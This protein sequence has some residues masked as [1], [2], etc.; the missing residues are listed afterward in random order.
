[1]PSIVQ[2]AV[3][4]Q[5]QFTKQPESTYQRNL[6][7]VSS[8]VGISASGY[9]AGQRLADALSGLGNAIMTYA[10]GQE[11]RKRVNAEKANDIVN[12]TTDK[13][14]KTLAAMD[15]INKSGQFQLRDNPYAVALIEQ[16][17]GKYFADKFNQQYDLLKAQEGVMKTP[18]E[19]AQRYE[20]EKTKF[21]HDNVDVAINE[22]NFHKGFYESN[23]KDVEDQVNAQVASQSKDL[24]AVRDGSI[25]AQTGEALVNNY[26]KT[27]EDL[28]TDLQKIPN[29]AMVT[30]FTDAEKIAWAQDTLQNV[31]RYYGS[32]DTIN[33]VGDMTL[34]A[35][36]ANGNPVKIKDVV[37]LSPFLQMAEDTN[38][39]KPSMWTMQQ[40]EAMIKT[41]SAA[42]LDALWS[43][44][45]PQ[46]QR[47]MKPFYSRQRLQKIAEA[48]EAK[49]RMVERNQRVLA[50]QASG[51]LLLNDYQ[52][53]IHNKTHIVSV[54]KGMTDEDVMAALL[55]EYERIQG[56]SDTNERN[57][58]FA[59]FIAYP[60]NKAL[61]AQLKDKYEW[62]LTSMTAEQMAEDGSLE[63]I[64]AAMNLYRN[65][66]VIFESN[67][68]KSLAD[69]MQTIKALIDLDGDEENAYKTFVNARVALNDPARREQVDAATK[70]FMDN[71]TFTLLNADTNEE[72]SDLTYNDRVI[73]SGAQALTRCLLATGLPMDAVASRVHS[74]IRNSYVVYNSD[75]NTAYYQIIPK[76]FF[77]EAQVDDNGN[78]QTPGIYS[79]TPYATATGFMDHEIATAP[80]GYN[81]SNLVWKYDPDQQKIQLVSTD[82]FSFS[83]S[84]TVDEFYDAV[85]NWGASQATSAPELTPTYTTSNYDSDEDTG[86]SLED[87][88]ENY[89][90]AAGVTRTFYE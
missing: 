49:K 19:E 69:N 39:S 68:G 48:E 50:G 30:G 71:Q 13:D 72:V 11:D 45:T 4:T 55:P 32:P 8:G 53:F 34:M 22:F 89:E 46:Q 6:R 60:P 77:S 23:R 35:N 28:V 88:A 52:R 7:Q 29:T 74:A 20:Q 21:Y 25:Q 38:A 51:Q 37:D 16:G 17:R 67:F 80:A 65:N 18:E 5:R 73:V 9:G 42:E 84:Y 12:S 70:D 75:P 58:E 76:V 10:V 83:T 27:P 33:A 82:G 36:D 41:T 59:K 81:S 62:A 26:G 85:N 56:I 61:R 24:K 63:G 31:A 43:K 79:N 3:G 47:I 15:L 57:I 78:E 86:D 44:Y 66:P 2:S 40:Q 54:P 14:W 87:T 64:S 1:M 90:A